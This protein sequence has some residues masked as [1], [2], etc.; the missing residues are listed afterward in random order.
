MSFFNNFKN[1][2]VGAICN[3]EWHRLMQMHGTP[4]GAICNREP[5]NQIKQ[6][7]ISNRSYTYTKTGEFL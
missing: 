1:A 2:S 7:A 6:F 5:W 4:V 3:R